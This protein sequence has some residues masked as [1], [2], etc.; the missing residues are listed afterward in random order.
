[1][2]ACSRFVTIVLVVVSSRSCC[3]L[4]SDVVLSANPLA[5]EETCGLRFPFLTTRT[6]KCS[7]VLLIVMGDSPY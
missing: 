2:K 4:L 1:M 5:C 3:P 6:N 7:S